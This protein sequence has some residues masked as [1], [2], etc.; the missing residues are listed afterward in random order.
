MASITIR[1]VPSETH[2]ELAAR[3]ALL[4]E[5]LQEYL[6]DQLIAIAE[7]PDARTLFARI[8]ERKAATGTRLPASK[9]LE[10]RDLDRK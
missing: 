3:A 4:G 5:S 7:R 6:R 8:R 2:N 9:I 1:D 10:Y